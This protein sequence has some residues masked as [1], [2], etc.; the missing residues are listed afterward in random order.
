MS[1][2]LL[3]LTHIFQTSDCD[4]I[5][6]SPSSS[7][8]PERESASEAGGL[9]MTS[10]QSRVCM[11]LYVAG[12]DPFPCTSMPFLVPDAE[13]AGAYRIRVQ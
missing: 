4:A 8:R 1:K 12:T 11:I 5:D 6:K 13:I 3:V 9:V 2:V 10:P 7:D